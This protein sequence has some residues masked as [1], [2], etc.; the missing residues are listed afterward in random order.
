MKKI[1]LSSALCTALVYGLD[2]LPAEKRTFDQSKFIPD[3][4]LIMDASYVDRNVKD[5][6]VK[7][8]AVPGVVHGLLGSH[9][10]G[11]DNHATYNVD[12]G[13]NLNYAEL[14]L[15]SSVDPFFTMDGIF[16]FSE[17]GVEIE[18]LFFTSNALGYGTKVKGGKFNSNFGYLNEQHHHT[19]DF[20][21]MPLVYESFLGMHGINETGAQ[22]Q[23]TAPTPFYLMAGF[24]IL[25]GENE[26]MFG[27]Q[28]VD[29]TVINPLA[30]PQTAEASDGAGLYVGYIKASHDI[31]DTTILGGISYAQGDSMID[32][33][34]DEEPTVFSGDAKLYGADLV[35]LHALDSYSSI[36]WQSEFL[37]RELDGIEYANN[38]LGVFISPTMLK[39]QSGLYS[40]LIYTH[41][42]NWRMGVR[43]DTI[44]Q[45]DVIENGVTIE[46]PDGLDKYTAM[47]EYHTSEFARFRLQYS[48]NNAMFDE[49]G[50]RKKIDT[51]ILQANISI[52]AHA[53]HSF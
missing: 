36:K 11:D 42:K 23:W 50:E 4:S 5:A 8:L 52:G 10:H 24:E 37:A 15:S 28:S 1:L 38:S 14:V 21:D 45:N 20:A 16:H 53:A 47:V 35:I 41:D 9:S 2:V 29:L 31:G 32:H 43:Y 33:S 34:V 48:R 30:I 6:D 3:I 13:F 40:Q 25:Q 19:W 17:N 12:N 7:H 26:Q 49:D 44:L 51:I 27:N 46:Q 22:I 18:E 39:K